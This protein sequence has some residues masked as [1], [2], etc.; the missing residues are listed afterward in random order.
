MEGKQHPI[1]K[2]I[3]TGGN[4]QLIETF[5]LRDDLFKVLHAESSI[6]C[7]N[8]LKENDDIDAILCEVFLPGLNAIE[9]HSMLQHQH[10]HA[11]TPFIILA[12]KAEPHRKA[13]AI[14]QHISDFYEGQIN[15]E[16]IHSRIIYLQRYQA[17][18]AIDRSSS[19]VQY[20]YKI[21]FF[22]RLL[23]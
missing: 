21:P 19:S 2:I 16:Q 12:E 7:I 1:L 15:P 9:L 8:V 5:T 14:E 17:Y 13:Q 4:T 20:L 18:F 22:K 11:N 3:Y 10:I 6:S 23:I